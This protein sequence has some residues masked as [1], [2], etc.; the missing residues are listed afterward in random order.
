MLSPASP[1]SSEQTATPVPVDPSTPA[2][3]ASAASA[4]DPSVAAPPLTDSSEP[5]V[6]PAPRVRRL[7]VFTGRVS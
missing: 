7:V 1:A 5:I 3:S 4:S 6:R 2:A